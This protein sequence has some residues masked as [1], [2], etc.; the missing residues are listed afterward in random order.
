MPRTRPTLFVF[1]LLFLAFSLAACSKP[2]EEAGIPD[3]ATIVNYVRET[4]MLE[5]ALKEDPNNPKLLVELGNTYYNWGQEEVDSKV[6]TAEPSAKWARA[7]ECY[8]KALSIEPA[9]VNVIVDRANLTEALGDN[10][11]A[12][13]EFRRAM[14]L[15][16]KL[17]QARI[18]LILALGGKKKDY[19]AA[20]SEYDALLAISPEQKDNA[21]LSEQVDKYRDQLKEARK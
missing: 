4:Q 18:N 3:N 12:I 19:K 13:S 6:E 11:K 2:K 8:D 16:P 9:N 17:L 7:V 20:V 14:K 21:S 10:D 5:S 15:D 1:I